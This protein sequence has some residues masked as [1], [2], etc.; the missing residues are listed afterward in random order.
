MSLNRLSDFSNLPKSGAIGSMNRDRCL[1]SF[2][3]KRRDDKKTFFPKLYS[4][5]HMPLLILLAFG[6][7]G[8]FSNRALFSNET[9]CLIDKQ[10]KIAERPIKNLAIISCSS[11]SGSTTLEKSFKTLGIETYRFHVLPE[12]MF[13][14]VLAQ[15]K[16]TRILLIDSM[17]DIISRKIAA[18]FQGIT[19]HTKLPRK[20][21]M[22]RYNKNRPI[23]LKFL[24]K[25]FNKKLFKIAQHHAFNDWKKFQ[26]DCLKDKSFNFEKKYQL[27]KIGNL[28]FLNLR[29][30]D[31]SNWAEI[32]RSIDLP[33][34]L[35]NFK[36]VAANQS[37][38]KWY[39]DIYQD[40]LNHFT[41]SRSHFNRILSNF[42]EEI[43]HFYT[44]QE[45]ENFLN[46]WEPYLID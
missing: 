17:R 19:K 30:D 23:F 40:F 26:Y 13:T 29:F 43:S 2:V 27:K 31:I 44:E 11:K 37:A 3:W 8:I 35:K 28:Y 24:Q 32:I 45:I 20:E 39:K 33:I 25:E 41:L 9:C 21:I 18:Y 16:D 15:E 6:F 10:A 36:I 1:S 38:E 7:V 42:S 34:D 46:K 12:R 5:D 4:G 22:S 14:Y